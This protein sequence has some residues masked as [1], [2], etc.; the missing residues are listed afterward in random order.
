MSKKPYNYIHIYLRRKI[1]RLFAGTIAKDGLNNVTE[2][3]L[4]PLSNSQKNIW[5]LEQSFHGASINNI[6]ETI[7][8]K[9]TFDVA[10]VQ[11]SLNLILEQDASLRTRI[12]LGE[13]KQPVQYEAPFEPE[14]F[15]VFDFSTTS[16]D[17]IRHWEESITREVMFL[18][19]SPL[20]YFAVIRVGEHEGGVLLKTHHIISDGWSLVALINRFAETYLALVDRREVTLEPSPS[21][22]LHVEEEQKYLSSKACGRDRAFWEEA[23]ENPE[24]PVSIKD[25]GSVAVSPVGRRLTFQLSEVLNHALY[26]FCQKH[27]VA[28]FACFYMAL[29]IYIK[30]IK[31]LDR[32]CIGVPIHNRVNV[33]DRDTTGMFVSTLPFVNELDE[34][35]SFEEFNANIADRWLELL[36]HQKFPFGE[37]ASIVQK[38][39]PDAGRLFQIVLS[40]HNSRTYSSKDTSVLFSGQWHYAGYQAEHLCI[41]LN[42][43]ESDRRYSVNY[44][45]L[46]QLFSEKEIENLHRY[47]VNILHQALTEPQRPIWQLPIMS[48]GEKE[49]VLFTF[50]RTDAPFFE[51][52]L[53]QKFA[54]VCQEHPARVAVIQDGRRYTYRALQQKA[55]A[56]AHALADFVPQGGGV[57]GVLLP[58]SYELFAA[59]AGV[60]QSGGA[61]VFLS[62]DFP[63]ER[64]R[65]IL[66]D[67]NAAAL[68]ST[69]EL[70]ER[71][72][73]LDEGI[74]VVHMDKVP[75]E[76]EEEFPCPAEPRS[77]AYL[78][79]TSGSTGKPK[80]VEIEQRS[81]LNFADAMKNL[82]GHGA[83]LSLCSV[84]FDA[85]LLESAVS[86]LNGRTVVLP[87]DG[88]QENPDCLAALIRQY[89]VG[90]LATT[91]SRLAAYLKSPAFRSALRGM[92][93]IVCGGEAFQSDLLKELSRL[94][95]ARIYNQY[96]PSETT[97]GVS[98]RLLN[99]AS[100]ITVGKPM[101]NCRAYVLDKRLMPLPI[102]VYGEL[103]IGGVCVGRG[104][105]GAPELTEKSFLQSPFEPEERIYRTGDVAAWTPEGEI[106]LQGRK[107]DQVKLRG[108]RIELSEISARLCLHP[109]IHQAAVRLL[110]K[111]HQQAIAA[112][113]VSD[114]EIPESEL[115]EFAATYLPGYMIPSFFM[116]VEEI[117]L[118]ANGKTDFS[119]L[120]EPKIQEES[121]GEV[122][123]A[124]EKILSVFR[125][126]LQKP[127]MTAGSNYFLFGG[128]SLNAVET[129]AELEKAFGVRLRVSDL[130]ACRTA[131]RLEKRLGLA[132]GKPAPAD[133]GIPKAREQEDYP[134][135]P[136]QQSAYFQSMLDPTGVSYNMPVAF[137]VK[138]GLDEERLAAA[139]ER[140]IGSEEVFRTAFVQRGNE[141]RQKVLPSVPFVLQTLRANSYEE[142]KE[143]FICPFD[144]SRPPLLRAAVWRQGDGSAV[145]FIDMHHIV[146]D[147]MS[148]AIVL[149]R[150]SDYYE[151]AAVRV[152]DVTYKDYACWLREKGESLFAGQREYWKKAVEGLSETPDLPADCTRPKNF[153]FRGGVHFCGLDE[154]LTA[155]C[156]E[157]CKQTG[158]TLFMLFAGAFGILVGK[159]SGSRDF[160]VGTP[161]SG[162]LRPELRDAAGMFINTL[163][164]RLRPEDE[165][166]AGDYFRRVRE[167][168]VG[169]LDHQDIPL[170]E[171]IALSGA[172]RSLGGNP[173]YNTMVSMR[174]VNEEAMTFAG[175]TVEGLPCRTGTAKLDIMLEVYREKGRF[176]FCFE[177][178]SSLFT[179]QSIALYGRSLAAILKEAISDDSLPLME[180]S[181]IAPADRYRLID[182]PN[183]MRTPF[184]DMPLDGQIDAFAE[185]TPEAPAV[186]F[187]GET[188]T[189]RALKERSASIAAQLVEAG[190]KR[191]DKIGV[192]C[193]R[194]F[195]MLC[196][197]V[198]VMKM[199]GAYVP[200]LA[201]FPENRLR[202]MMEQSGASL[203]LTDG[204]TAK[205]LPALPCLTVVIDGKKRD[206]VP[207][208]GRTSEDLI[209]VLYTSG[210]T[211]RPKGV[212]LR[213]RSL[214]NL[215]ISVS[216]LFAPVEGNI[217]C[218]TNI[219]F[220]TFITETL[221]P[222]ALGRC[223]VMA[224]EEEMMLPW[225]IAGLI[226]VENAAVMQ[227]TP[228]RLQMCLGNRAF[229]GAAGKLKLMILAG[230]A[231]T[232][233]LRDS[234]RETGCEKIVNLYGP[235]EAAV[236]VTKA[237]VTSGPVTIGKPLHNCRAY[238]LD[239][240][241]HPALPTA[242]GELYLAG[243]CLSTGYIGNE[244][245][246]KES[247]VSDP[248]FPGERMYK[249]GD[250]ARLTADGSIDYLG[251]RDHQV[252]LNGQRVEL[253]EISDRILASGFVREAAVIAVKQNGAM[254]LR[255]FVV[256]DREDYVKDIRDFLKAELPPYMV[257]GAFTVLREMPRTATGK[258]DR[259]ALSRW[260]QENCSEATKE[261][262]EK[263]VAASAEEVLR[264]QA[265]TES[266]AWGLEYKAAVNAPQAD[267]PIPEKTPAK[268]QAD[269]AK[270][271]PVAPPA[272]KT[273]APVQA[274]VPSGCK[275]EQVAA[276]WREAL[277]KEAVLPEVSFFEQ[278]GTS[279]G[280]LNLLSGY[281]NLGVTMTLAQFYENP[282]LTGQ[283][284][285]MGVEADATEAEILPEEPAFYENPTLTG[286][287]KLM[288]V[289]ADATEAEIPPEEPAF[290][291]NPTLAGQVKLMGVE[292]DAT[293]PQSPPE[294]PAL[295]E[296]SPDFPTVGAAA[297]RTDSV[298][299]KHTILLTGATGFLGAHL[300]KYLLEAGTAKIIC[301]IRDGNPERLRETLVWYFGSGWTEAN[302][303]ALEVL[304]GDVTQKNLGLPS[305]LTELWR[306]KISCC[307]HAAADVRHYVSGGSEEVNVGGTQNAIDFCRAVGAKLMHIST[308]SVSAEYIVDEPQRRILFTENDLDMGQNWEGNTYI[309]SK[310]LAEKRV[311]EAAQN[312]LD[313]KIFRVGRLVGRSSDGVFQ[314]NPD[315][316]AFY[317]F[318]KGM[319]AL[320]LCPRCFVGLPM[321]LT[322]VDQCAKAIAA[323]LDAGG[324]TFHVCNPYTVPLR[325]IV[326]AVKGKK[327]P[328]VDEMEFE[329]HL[330]QKLAEGLGMKLAALVEQYNRLR[331]IPQNIFPDCTETSKQLSARGFHWKEPDL[332]LLLRSF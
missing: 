34:N 176:A 158:I 15:P 138:G 73:L 90:F 92:E 6:C 208:A 217:L 100:Q 155:Q 53:Y 103:Y 168:V 112:Y 278:G 309:K 275:A 316:N 157:Y 313:A 327:L 8:I 308:V 258:V 265:K 289:E 135:T 46:T 51:G 222:L 113:Y 72:G 11:K 260:N 283:M 7:R 122:T 58:K 187:H 61:F 77:L 306:G 101:P 81:L 226:E 43:M 320:E 332:G 162:R 41:H 286:Q 247:F 55:N 331:T 304:S 218:T 118:T 12:I 240:H 49:K 285:L 164:L 42:S 84:S 284:E 115:L 109:Q 13:G 87:M 25:C 96:G 125:R 26:D 31:G 131:E 40:F 264:P 271:E 303:K 99:T 29:A 23:M 300:I 108:L 120:P 319:E 310:F 48:L 256:S 322:A 127:R 148:A 321:E 307:V 318:V 269:T 151:G 233:N 197:L 107:D 317:S 211:G 246:T 174:P 254:S 326:T 279:L 274:E 190:G 281:F 139:F 312:G 178:A 16:E 116:G 82:Y 85:F 171:V 141:I 19:E 200:M 329:R 205:E 201:S 298:Q 57:V 191:G 45:Y 30:R 114:G 230:E 69:R 145:V 282:T 136:A 330:S 235:S 132:E 241:L 239:G 291:E 161:V 98:A 14:Q 270:P 154:A 111:E 236:Y 315:S 32:L 137:R 163:P 28:P 263:A 173:L 180:I 9:G 216:E 198:A 257:P 76:A 194:G 37:I 68:V 175:K 223:V 38:K 4:Y 170:E 119:R 266:K 156:E 185:M 182:V 227:L 301:P 128:D 79:Y 70:T 184:L 242:R 243:E 207:P 27:R 130:Y 203:L 59:M 186:V 166:T 165:L 36:R 292:A 296:E 202:Y 18:I 220:D 204:E 106:L 142:A 262:S 3:N 33:T 159:L 288:G 140:L 66:R 121:A 78:V 179:E 251:R 215:L 95:N 293:E 295:T 24:P 324:F 195:D 117:P 67:S 150:L 160:A 123:E 1:E 250:M 325:D 249:S 71:A 224:D 225:K 188:M 299:K 147:G 110:T 305:A 54:E 75:D 232:K 62:P 102:G 65:E 83:V 237:D 169:L 196:A 172:K 210:S 104:Y 311:R 89:A 88:E 143:A 134:L 52:T 277:G 209:H 297:P 219:V 272:A 323:L 183:R 181:G 245:L 91:P 280:A 287:V 93:T 206:F 199:G 259:E 97:I 228:S 177:Y 124:Q 252:K 146:G 302:W 214:S 60:F 39:N 5:A 268:V 133:T 86:I 248:F 294:A 74:P 167:E 253:D 238:V 189:F 80:G 276:L 35:W 20:Y 17:G 314:K 213:H 50:N 255:A 273:K 105:R 229:E 212:M 290:Y 192:L 328:E 193:R 56:V 47:L 153:D 152:P 244:E 22:R 267:H 94:T 234:L 221:L 21:Y 261:A 129:L 2:M 149:S 63:R 126:V 64:L 44:D 144:L 231:L 10:L